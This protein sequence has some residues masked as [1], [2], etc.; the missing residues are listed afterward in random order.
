MS[1]TRAEESVSRPK[2]W[3]GLILLFGAGVLTGAVTTFLLWGVD[4]SHRGE[5]GPAAQYER[6][7]KRLTEELSLTA[8]QQT[9]IEPIVKQAHLEILKLRVSHQGEI[10]GIVGRGLTALKDKLTAAQQSKLDTMYAA[11]QARWRASQ[12]YLDMMKR[13]D[14]LPR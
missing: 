5:R 3:A 9:D 7:M 10:E 12:D 11:L 1:L 14:P 13:Q 6:I 4:W 8:G 2:L